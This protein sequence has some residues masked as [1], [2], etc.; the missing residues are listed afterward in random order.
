MEGGKSFAYIEI[1]FL[2]ENFRFPQW[3]HPVD[4]KYQVVR[5]TNVPTAAPVA[6]HL[7]R[8]SNVTRDAALEHLLKYLPE[9]KLRLQKSQKNRKPFERRDM[10]TERS[11]FPIWTDWLEDKGAFHPNTPVREQLQRLPICSL[12]S[13]LRNE[14]SLVLRELHQKP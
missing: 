13:S 11:F 8:I 4:C 3:I 10:K 6:A 2:K 7:V 12:S 9:L 1:G 5:I 14:G